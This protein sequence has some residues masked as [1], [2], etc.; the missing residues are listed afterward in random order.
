MLAVGTWQS[1]RLAQE[2]KALAAELS[3]LRGFSDRAAAPRKDDAA[4]G[5]DR[6]HE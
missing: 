5:G 2:H 1:T 6:Q 4:N 3:S